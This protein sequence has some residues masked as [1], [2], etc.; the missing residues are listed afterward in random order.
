MVNST[1]SKVTID[2]MKLTKWELMM[3]H[4]GM[5]QFFCRTEMKNSATLIMLGEGMK[6]P[7]PSQLLASL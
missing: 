2:K 1:L 4:M 5:N 7:V 6:G 3:W